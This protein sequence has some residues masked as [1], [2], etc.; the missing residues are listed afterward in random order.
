MTEQNIRDIN[1]TAAF[2]GFGVDLF[3]SELLGWI[4]T[5]IMLA[6]KGITVE[7]GDAWP[8]DVLLVRQIVGVVGAVV[9]GVVAGYV[10]GRRG[11][12]HGVL[13]SVIGL[14]VFFCTFSVLDGL[15]LNV[16]DIGFIVLNLVGAGYGGG[17]GERWRVR[18]DEEN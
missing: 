1:W 8:P 14:A 18:R 2:M 17:V 16:G 10:A 3:L 6:L 12:L 4:V 13:G 15:S 11:S 9:G 5:A 7:V